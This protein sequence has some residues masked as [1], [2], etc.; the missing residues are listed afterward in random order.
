MCPVVDRTAMVTGAS[1]RD[2][3]CDNE[4]TPGRRAR[5]SSR[6]VIRHPRTESLTTSPTPGAVP[7]STRTPRW[8]RVAPRSP[9][10]EQLADSSGSPG[11]HRR[12]S[13]RRCRVGMPVRGLTPPTRPGRPRSGQSPAGSSGLSPNGACRMRA[14]LQAS[15]P[16]LGAHS[17]PPAVSA[18]E[19][20]V[21]SLTSLVALGAYELREE[22][23]R[24]GIQESADALADIPCHEPPTRRRQPPGDL[25]HGAPAAPSAGEGRQRSS[26]I[27]SVSSSRRTSL[28]TSSSMRPSSRAR[29][30]TARSASSI[31]RRS[32]R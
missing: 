18:S 29:R 27:S 6:L 31:A 17:A 5:A 2:R 11:A 8:S 16:H 10:R 25:R 14:Q 28:T 13:P 19:A 4:G 32:R 22:R 1:S 12:R 26:S 9:P 24:A 20:G 3:S 23:D 21:A 7:P 15:G 30:N